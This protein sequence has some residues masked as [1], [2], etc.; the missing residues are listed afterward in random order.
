MRS[1]ETASADMTGER[2]GN[3]DFIMTSAPNES[4]LGIHVARSLVRVKSGTKPRAL[5]KGRH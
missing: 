2:R 1:Y 3:S 4:W 5:L